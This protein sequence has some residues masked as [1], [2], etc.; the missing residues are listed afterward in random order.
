LSY[1]R[2]HR[3]L[4]GASLLALASAGH[5]ATPTMA[6]LTKQ[7]EELKASLKLLQQQV[8]AQ[9]QAQAAASPPRQ[10]AALL[11]DAGPSAA[12]PS[13]AGT[14]AEAAT[15]G[16]IDGLRTDL[17]NYKYDQRRSRET[18]T[19]LTSRGTT[20]GGTVQTRATFQTPS[21]KNGSLAVSDTRNSSFDIPQALFNMSGSL[22]RDYSE[23]RNLDFRLGFAYAKTSPVGDGSSFNVTDAYI[24]YSPL[25]TLT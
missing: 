14:S 10:E 7:I 3:A 22:Y 8:Q 15:K 12:G 24:R 6:E 11:S 20:F 9:A 16:D 21:T 23:G 1:R 4:I 5:A 17:E 2:K 19:A 13:A 18:K 25:S